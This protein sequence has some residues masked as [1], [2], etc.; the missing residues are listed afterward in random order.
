MDNAAMKHNE[1]L[2]KQNDV[3]IA[4]LARS[5]LGI[6]LIHGVVTK[7]KRNPEAYVDAYNALDGTIGV[8]DAAK[9]AKVSQPTMTEILKSW[10]AEGIVYNVGDARKPLYKR[11][12]VLSTAPRRESRR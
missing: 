4:L 2:I 10:E 9:V 7:G 5:T 1:I 3:L 12:L 8:T 11:L 6:E